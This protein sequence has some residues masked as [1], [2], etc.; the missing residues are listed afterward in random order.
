MVRDTDRDVGIGAWPPAD[1]VLDWL[2]DSDPSIRWQVLRDL[3]D[4]DDVVA[5]RARVAEE[6]WGRRLL[7]EQR[8]DG[9]WGDGEAHPFWWTNMYTL[10]YLRD[11]GVDPKSDRTR[12]AIELVDSSVNWGPWHGYSPFFEGEEE[13]CIN[14]RVVALGAYFGK[15]SLRLV[16]LLLSE[17]LGD[18][19]WNCEALNGSLRSSFHTTICVLEGLLAHEQ[20]FGAD[21]A[22]TEARERGGEYLLKRHLL[23]RLS[24]GEIIDEGWR[25]LAYPPLWHYDVLR[26]LEYAVN[27]GFKDDPRLAEA[28]ETVERRQLPDG[29]WCLD[30]RHKDTLYEEIAG[31][32]GEPNRWITLRALRALKRLR[33]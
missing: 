21:P 31:A 1:S 7:N 15:P 3:V 24:T 25:C 14:G 17:Q 4:V 9:Q 12:H 8:P 30:V 2:L 5:E 11:L 29:R 13:P 10:L 6:G 33:K 27:A 20:S 18:G 22:I 23:R 26:G 19:G 16:D 28:V 32:P